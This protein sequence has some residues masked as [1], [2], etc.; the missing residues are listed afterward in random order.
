MNEQNQTAQKPSTFNADEVARKIL[1]ERQ[2]AS[3]E[4]K[5]DRL[6]TLTDG[7]GENSPGLAG[8]LHHVEKVIYGNGRMG[9]QTQV[10]LIWSTWVW[11]LCT[12]SAAAGF[13]IRE[14][15]KALWHA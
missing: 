15:V 8:R 3:I 5:I 14:A 4:R 12:L 1:D 9:I 11:F 6:I 7:D 10:R 2:F 13:G